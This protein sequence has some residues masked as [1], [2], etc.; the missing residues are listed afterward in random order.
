MGG[1][2]FKLLAGLYQHNLLGVIK[3]RVQ[4]GV[5]YLSWSAGS[6]VATPSIHTTNG[7]PLTPPSLEALN[8][9]DYQINLHFPTG[10]KT[11]RA[12]AVKRG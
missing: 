12:R 8:L 1:N 6:L 4:V 3:K 5:S 9:V 11:T 10:L 7:M 2:D